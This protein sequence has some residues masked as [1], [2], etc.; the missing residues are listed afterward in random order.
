M[1]FQD[2][3]YTSQ[4]RLRQ[5]FAAISFSLGRR[6]LRVDGQGSTPPSR[7]LFVLSGL[8]GDSVMSLPAIAAA[9]ELWPDA[10]ITVLGKTRNRELL[11]ADPN[12]DEFYV[13]DAD[14]FSLRRSAEVG[15]LKSWLAKQK[16]DIAIILLGD[17]YAHLLAKAG[18]PVR[19]GVKG[20]ILEPC[21]THTYE[22]G[23]PR[24]WG[25]R[26]RLNCL[27]VLGAEVADCV[28]KLH[29][30]AEAVETATGKL[31]ELG[32]TRGERYI[33]FHPFGSTRRQWWP[34]KNVPEFLRQAL[35][36]T[37]MRVVLLGGKETQ[38]VETGTK[39]MIDTRGSLTI[40]E[41][42]AVIDSSEM[43]VTTDS[44]PFHIAGG[45]G[46]QALGLFRSR[47]PEHAHAYP[48]ARVLFGVDSRCERECEWDRCVSDPCLQMSQLNNIQTVIASILE[49]VHA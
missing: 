41:L 1:A 8:L 37:G 2:A 48:N 20:T 34:M 47:R 6:F 7:L 25:T 16:F 21:L 30:D 22:I 45:L 28:P 10:R 27:R 31:S 42:L 40:P 24:E 26:E 29:V 17:Q 35:S 15:E 32:L 44:G 18:I 19:V 33:A 11:K 49:G 9:S 38:A 14:P 4:L 13:C 12:I 23:S 43:V 5:K 3:V 46:K 36:Q 39:G